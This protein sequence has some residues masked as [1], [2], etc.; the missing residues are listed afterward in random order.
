MRII[1]TRCLIP[2]SRVAERT[3][4]QTLISAIRYNH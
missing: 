4:F 3:Q 1:L 2:G